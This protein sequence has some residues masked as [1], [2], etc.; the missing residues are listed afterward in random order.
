MVSIGRVLKERPK[1]QDM[2]I[3]PINQIIMIPTQTPARKWTN[4]SYQASFSNNSKM[5]P[6]AKNRVISSVDKRS[7]VDRRF[8]CYNEKGGEINIL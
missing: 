8:M 3:R 4:S 7:C 5:I 6:R 2:E 1:K